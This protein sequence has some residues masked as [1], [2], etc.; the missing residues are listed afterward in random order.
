MG[1]YV[2]FAAPPSADGP[3]PTPRPVGAEPE[4]TSPGGEQ[5]GLVS[6][7]MTAASQEKS[8]EERS[9]LAR[10]L[11]MSP[12]VCLAL[13]VVLVVAGGLLRAAAV[14]SAAAASAA[15]CVVACA[16]SP[17]LAVRLDRRGVARQLRGIA[18][19]Q[20][21]GDCQVGSGAEP[22]GA[23]PEVALVSVG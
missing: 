15:L 21:G 12:G 23:E 11:L 4:N 2:W 14:A 1:W 19:G 22:D 13:A 5:R 18:P 16:V 17:V 7:S 6:A 3:Q 8:P 20:P 9:L 10:A